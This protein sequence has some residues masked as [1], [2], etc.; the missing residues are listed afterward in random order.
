MLGRGPL[1]DEELV[2]RPIAADDGS[3]V[4][5][6]DVL[7]A[8]E[9]VDDV[10]AGHVLGQEL[11]IGA[12]GRHEILIENLALPEHADDQPVELGQRLCG[13][14]ADERLELL[15]LALPIMAIESGF[16]GHARSVAGFGVF[17]TSDGESRLART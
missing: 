15:P 13:R 9:A 3:H 6:V 8:L 12:F 17:E 1:A 11:R 5:R 2:E 4:A 7:A 16:D 14:V 10:L